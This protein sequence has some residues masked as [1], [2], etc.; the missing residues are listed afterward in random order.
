MQLSSVSGARYVTQH[1][2]SSG[3]MCVIKDLIESWVCHNALRAG[4]SRARQVRAR[5]T[6]LR[7]IH[8]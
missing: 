4:T 1:H 2:I 5:E 6:A 7:G 8:E 3:N